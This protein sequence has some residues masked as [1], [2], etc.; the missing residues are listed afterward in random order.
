MVFYDGK[1]YV[2]TWNDYGTQIWKRTRIE[3]LGYW[4]ESW[5]QVNGPNTKFNS[6]SNYGSTSMAV[7]DNKLYVGTIN[8]DDGP[9]IWE[10][11]RVNDSWEKRASHGF[12]FGAQNRS[13][14]SM[15]VYDRAGALYAGTFNN[16]SGAQIWKSSGGMN[17]EQDEQ[18]KKTPYFYDNSDITSMAVYSGF[19]V[20]GTENWRTGTEIW[21]YEA[22]SDFWMQV[23]K[24]DFDEQD[25]DITSNL[26]TTSIFVYNNELY[27][28]SQPPEVPD[29]TSGSRIWRYSGGTDWKLVDNLSNIKITSIAVFGKKL[30]VGTQNDSTGAEIWVSESVSGLP[31]FSEWRRANIDG[32]GDPSNTAATSMA[33]YSSWCYNVFF[34]G[35]Y[36]FAGTRI[37]ETRGIEC[38]PHYP[39]PDQRPPSL[40]L[41]SHYRIFWIRDLLDG[42]FR[43]W[44]L[45]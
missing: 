36:N 12:G 34:V 35:T 21:A 5:K 32:F 16:V 33:V 19:L 26:K 42:V 1:L 37:Y 45:P 22:D 8:L 43:R 38:E 28:I 30:Y 27:A 14:T 11:N 23:N 2:G 44:W 4:Y 40:Y 41:L 20:V 7:Y 10:Y 15:A 13:I 25:D 9:E 18:I 24:D 6:P 31:P 17:W 3:K 29:Q 39:D